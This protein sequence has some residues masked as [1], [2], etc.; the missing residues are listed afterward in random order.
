MSVEEFFS[1]CNRLILPIYFTEIEVYPYGMA[2]FKSRGTGHGWI[3]YLDAK[4]R[5]R[6]QHRHKSTDPYHDQHRRVLSVEEAVYDVIAHDTWQLKGRPYPA[7]PIPYSYVIR[8][9]L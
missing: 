1:E 5:V 3:L 2:V 8:N 7:C 4:G 6:T 9:G